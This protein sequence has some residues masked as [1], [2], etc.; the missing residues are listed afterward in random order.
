MRLASPK[1]TL[2][3]VAQSAKKPKKPKVVKPS[4]SI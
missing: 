1:L 3:D 4:L 2:A